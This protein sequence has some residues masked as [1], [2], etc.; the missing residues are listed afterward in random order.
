M[1]TFLPVFFIP[2][3]APVRNGAVG[4]PRGIGKLLGVGWKSHQPGNFP[5]TDGSPYS[6][7]ERF[8]SRRGNMACTTPQ[9][10]LGEGL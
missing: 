4:Q 5:G 7:T 6:A 3:V 1:K 2:A 10:L 8:K 9:V